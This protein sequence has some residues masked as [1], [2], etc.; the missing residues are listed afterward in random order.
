M[1]DVVGNEFGLMTSQR[2]SIPSVAPSAT[3]WPQCQ[4]QIMSRPNSTHPL[5]SK[6][7]TTEM[8]SQHSYSTSIHTICLSCT[9]RPQYTTRQTDTRQT[10]RATGRGRLCYRIGGLKRHNQEIRIIVYL[11]DDWCDAAASSVFVANL[12]LTG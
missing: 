11:T 8:S 4:C 7:V 1:R 5:G 9:V 2:L 3:V 10:D 12:A 6:M